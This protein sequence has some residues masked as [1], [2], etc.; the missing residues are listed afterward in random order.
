MQ[1]SMHTGRTVAT[2]REQIVSGELPA[3]TPLVETVLAEALGV[4]RGPVRNALIELEGEGLVRTGSNGRSL[5]AG[6]RQDDL[7][8]LLA[9]RFELESLAITWGIERDHDSAPI[10]DALQAMV[11][12]GASTP[13]LIELDLGFHRKLVELAGSTAL[14]NS[15]LR[16][17]PIIHATITVGNSRLGVRDGKAGFERIIRS[18]TPVFEAVTSGDATGASK[19]LAQQFSVTAEMY[20]VDQWRRAD[21][22]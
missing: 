6:F 9:V 21:K 8:D 19:L 18:H 16:L 11:D 1:R 5:V 15:W 7:R 17:A 12:E 10:K 22:S 14:L 2:L 13:D 4:S 20:R 3:G